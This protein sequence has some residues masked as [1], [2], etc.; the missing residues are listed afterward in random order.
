[1][2]TKTLADRLIEMKNQEDGLRGTELNKVRLDHAK[3]I[4]G[5]INKDQQQ[6]FNDKYSTR[7]RQM[8][9]ED[10]GVKYPQ[11]LEQ[12]QTLSDTMEQSVQFYTRGDN[13]LAPMHDSETSLSEEDNIKEWPDKPVEIEEKAGL[14]QRLC[15]GL[16]SF[17]SK[18]SEAV[19]SAVKSLSGSASNE[20]ESQ[21]D[22]QNNNPS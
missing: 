9:A 13:G 7:D 22:N 16:K 5:K 20:K 6:E 15:D 3:E 17:A 21:R 11:A 4:F 2:P 14:F 19:S 12:L 1:M 10:S 18:I 8:I